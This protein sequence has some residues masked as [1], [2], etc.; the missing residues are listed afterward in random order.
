MLLE[1]PV[2]SPSPVCSADGLSRSTLGLEERS[3]GFVSLRRGFESF[4]F[5][6]V[7]ETV[8]DILSPT[9]EERGMFVLK[10]DGPG[11]VG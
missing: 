7:R 11:G 3:S 5:E 10:D 9:L 2:Y 1:P 4:A 8:L 6:V